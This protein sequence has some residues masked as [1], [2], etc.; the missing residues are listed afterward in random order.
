[1]ASRK[2]LCFSLPASSTLS[3]VASHWNCSDPNDPAYIFNK[4]VIP[5]PQV[6]ADWQQNDST[7]PDYIK[8]RPSMPSAQIQS[9]WNQTTTT[10]DDYIKNKPTLATVATS[11]SYNDLS[12]K[13]TIPAAQVN[14]D[15]DATSGVARILNKPTIPTVVSTIENGNSNAIS[16]DAVY[17]ALAL[18]ADNSSLA[19]VATSGSYNDLTDKPTIDDFGGI[20]TVA[21]N[22]S[23]N[24]FLGVALYLLAL[25]V[26][27]FTLLKGKPLSKIFISVFCCPNL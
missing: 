14:S 19:T 22:I 16:S 26:Y 8:H 2:F 21:N 5:A 12:N 10:A 9:D 15:W 25:I 23:T 11:G 17:D 13:P 4:P 18:K 1:M 3:A 7:Q 6:Q 27:S 24:E 20:V